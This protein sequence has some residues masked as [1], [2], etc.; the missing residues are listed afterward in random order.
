MQS[1]L[2]FGMHGDGVWEDAREGKSLCH[3]LAFHGTGDGG[4]TV[5][6]T[7]AACVGKRAGLAF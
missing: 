4:F 5:D 1:Q 7:N 2:C 3:Y 6:D